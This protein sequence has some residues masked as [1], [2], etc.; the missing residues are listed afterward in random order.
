M[1]GWGA[2]AL[3]ILIE[4]RPEALRETDAA[5]G[6]VTVVVEV[7]HAYSVLR[8]LR[9]DLRMDFE[10]LSDLCAVDWLE[11][12]R[13]ERFDVVYHLLSI[14]RNRR[15]RVKVS[16]D[17]SV[18]EVDSVCSIWP[19]ANW[20]EREVF[21]LYGIGFRN[22]PDLRR[23]LLQQDF[24]GHPLRKDFPKRGRAKLAVREG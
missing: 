10:M 15:L 1:E 6:D 3:E 7:E 20:M 21:D 4:E 16:V 23:I 11:Q 5:H 9:D 8:Q 18:C 17:E 14:R 2:P 22:H 12:G 13:A 19:A 24:E